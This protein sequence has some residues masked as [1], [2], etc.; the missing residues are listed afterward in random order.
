M[1]VDKIRRSV[2][3]GALVVAVAGAVW[4]GPQL[5]QTS[6]FDW[7]SGGTSVQVSSDADAGSTVSPMDFDW[8]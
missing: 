6:D 2:T 1:S 5:V 7:T 8:T 3:L 4:A